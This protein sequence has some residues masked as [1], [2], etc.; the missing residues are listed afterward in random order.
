MNLNRKDEQD[1][2]ENLQAIFRNCHEA[3]GSKKQYKAELQ[4]IHDLKI[5]NHQMKF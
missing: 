4:R 5:E 3:F 1:K 2:I